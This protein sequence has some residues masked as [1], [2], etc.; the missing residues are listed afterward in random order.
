MRETRDDLG[1][2][3][4]PEFHGDGRGKSELDEIH[5]VDVANQTQADEARRT[6]MKEQGALDEIALEQI[7]ARA[8]VFQDF[9][10]KILAGQQQAK[11]LF[12]QSGI[13]EECGEHL[14]LWVIEQGAEVVTRSG[15]RE[16]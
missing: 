14:G 8:D 12:I 5:E 10:G 3:D 9:G 2:G 15:A 4:A 11:L 7:F 6:G 1:F 13:I 16:L